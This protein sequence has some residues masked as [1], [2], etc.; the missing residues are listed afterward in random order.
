MYCRQAK[1]GNT[2]SLCSLWRNVQ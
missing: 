2:H 1:Y